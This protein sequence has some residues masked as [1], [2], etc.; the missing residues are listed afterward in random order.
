M[1]LP[2]GAQELGLAEDDPRGLTVTGGLPYFGG[3]GNNYVTHSIAEMMARVRARPGMKGMVTANG[4]YVTKQSGGIY[5]TEPPAK[6]FQPKDPAKRLGVAWLEV[7]NRGG[8]AS[9]RYFNGASRGGGDPTTEEEFGELIRVLEEQL[10]GES[11][12]SPGQ[13]Q[14]R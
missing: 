5:S 14:W 1:H 8:K 2:I 9:L 12:G 11:P 7:S 10:A 4:N 3:P 6:A 13:V